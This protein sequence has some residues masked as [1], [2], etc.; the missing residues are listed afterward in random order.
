MFG[1]TLIRKSELKELRRSH[2]RVST[3]VQVRDWFSGWKDLEIIWDY[4][5]S[6]FYPGTIDSCR[7][8]YADARGTDQYGQPIP[9]LK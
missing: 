8:R 6:E 7:S 5:L 2:Q 1:W 4:V 9:E 3:L